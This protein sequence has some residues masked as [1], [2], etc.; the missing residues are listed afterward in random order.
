MVYLVGAGPGDPGL[1][2]LRGA[3]LLGRAN[4]VIHDG[5]VNTELL[6]LAPKGAEIVFGGKH[7][8]SR[9]VSQ[10]ELNSLLVTK[11]QEGKQ[12]V[13]L[14]GGDPYVFA[15][16]GEEAEALFEAGIPFEVVPGVS[17]AEAVPNY[18]GIPLT[19]R[20][21]CSSYTV[22]TGHTDPASP[23]CRIDWPA[24][25]RPEGTLVV[26]MGLKHIRAISD[27]LIEHG[28]QASTPAAV[29]RWGTWGSQQVIEGTL[30]TLA[31]QVEQH[32]MEP[33]VVTVIGEVV[34]LRSRLNWLE[35][36]CLWGQRI[37]VT[38]SRDQAS[39]LSGPLRE[40]GAD[41]LEI[42][43]VR[44]RPPHSL[45]P[46]REALAGLGS[47]DWLV[48]TSGNGVARFFEEF[49][50]KYRDIR[51]LGAIQ[52]AAVGPGTAARIRDYH[53]QIDVVPQ[54]FT[55]AK[56]VEALAKFESVENLRFLLAR[57]E[58]ANPELP[59]MLEA[60][61][62][63]VDDIAC[64]RTE[65]EPSSESRDVVRLRQDGAD[66]IVFTSGSTVERFHAL[67]N[68]PELMQR[69]PR[70]KLATIGPETSK[71]LAAVGLSPALEA[72]PHTIDGLVTALRGC[73]EPS[74]SSRIIESAE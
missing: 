17:S 40:L 61:G 74:G 71:L 5:L 64:Y 41:V 23:E 44:T 70:L 11:A 54:E 26:L 39:A 32:R 37:V 12:V 25:S 28:K 21:F 72:N 14:K 52:I 6:R 69:F 2:T 55:A 62:G 51:D 4:V 24:V 63:I 48:F 22:I 59:R 8:K 15:R 46:L 20:R 33:P 13:R 9:C 3:E 49:F 73:V 36:R 35:R 53:L 58:K 67:F 19:H 66:W 38:R 18:A 34:R 31:D 1:L 65:P 43:V 16:G 68:L 29:I 27:K 45:T 10:T 56:I 57:A 42:P 50:K 30:A 7:E 60:K 47:Y